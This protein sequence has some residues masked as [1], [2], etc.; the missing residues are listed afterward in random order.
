MHK[1]TFWASA[2]RNKKTNFISADNKSHAAGLMTFRVRAS[3]MK[4]EF[5]VLICLK[6]ER[7]KSVIE[8]RHQHC[9]AFQ[10]QIKL[11]ESLKVKTERKTADK[12]SSLCSESGPKGNPNPRL[13]WD[14]AEGHLLDE[15]QFR[16]GAERRWLM[17]SFLITHVEVGVHLGGLTMPSSSYLLPNSLE[18]YSLS[19]FSQISLTPA[20]TGGFTT[21]E[22]LL[23]N[24]DFVKHSWTP[25]DN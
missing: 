21:A 10:W 11:Q 20:T 2:R 14:V 8:K 3:W 9:V 13:S 16:F 23:L 17:V 24:F 22:N 18:I 19:C 4:T 6:K 12:T 5:I 15:L 25:A 1:R 7:K